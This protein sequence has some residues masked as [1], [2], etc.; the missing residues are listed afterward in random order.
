MR[1]IKKNGLFPDLG[2]GEYGSMIRNYLLSFTFSLSFPFWK[3]LVKS[4]GVL[5]LIALSEDSVLIPS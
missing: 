5:L 3:K 4:E 2:K 1:L